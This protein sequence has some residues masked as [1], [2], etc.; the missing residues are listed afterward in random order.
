[1]CTALSSVCT[2]R[3]RSGWA[4]IAPLANTAS[5][6]ART[7]CGADHP[8]PAG[9]HA[10]HLVVVGP[11]RHQL[12]D[13]GLAQGLVE[14]RLDVVGRCHQV[15]GLGLDGD[16]HGSPVRRAQRKTTVL[17]P[18]I[19]T[20][21]STCQRTARASTTHSTSRPT[22]VICSADM[23]VIDPLDVLLDDR[24]FVEVGGDV[25]RGGADQ[26][27]A[28]RMGLVVRLGALEAGQEAVVDVD[29]PALQAAQNS[30]L[31]ICM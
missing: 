13:V 9:V 1:L 10:E 11:H 31:R 26:L 6:E 28:T 19:S 23:R 25:V 30:A 24:A 8:R 4:W 3:T 22:A 7:A 16:G 17:W 18:F 12:V 5:N 21:R 29:R 20:R 15:G 27:H 2:R 14:L